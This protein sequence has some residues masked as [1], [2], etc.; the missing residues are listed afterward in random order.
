MRRPSFIFFGQAE[1]SLIKNFYTD[2][3]GK[4]GDDL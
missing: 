3:T 4:R 2:K 1:L